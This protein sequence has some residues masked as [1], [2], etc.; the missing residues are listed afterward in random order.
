MAIE[1]RYLSL[2]SRRIPPEQ[3]TIGAAYVIHARNGGV[4]VA[5]LE[6]GNLGYRLHREKFG[7]HFLFVEYDWAQGPPHGTAIPL[8]TLAATPP[9]DDEALLAWLKAQEADHRDEIDRAWE[10]VLGFHPSRL[11]RSDEG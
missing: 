6:G 2:L 4:G 8:A 9:D 1:D 11:R 7:S 5:V 10:I 3:I